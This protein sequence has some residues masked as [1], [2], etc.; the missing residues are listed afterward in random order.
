M[1]ETPQADRILKISATADVS[2]SNT[3]HAVIKI[4]DNGSGI[5]KELE[6]KLFTPF[7]TTKP[8]GMGIGLSLCQ[9][10]VERQGGSIDW[11]R[12]DGGGTEFTLELPMAKVEV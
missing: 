3:Q 10:I 8:N 11:A 4:S 1:N 2:T 7:F 6:S 5:H 12:K 9:S